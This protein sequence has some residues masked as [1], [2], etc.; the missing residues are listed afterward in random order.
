MEIQKKLKD[1]LVNFEVKGDGESFCS[2][3]YI[4]VSY[5]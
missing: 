4:I 5:G 1:F 2:L 3:P